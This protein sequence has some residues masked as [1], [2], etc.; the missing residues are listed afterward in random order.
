VASSRFVEHQAADEAPRSLRWAA[1]V[2]AVLAT[3][4]AAAYQL[5]AVA[6]GLHAVAVVAL[7]AGALL[8]SRRLVPERGIPWLVAGCAVMLIWTTQIEVYRDPSY[9]GMAYLLLLLTAF[10]PFVLSTA[11]FAVAVALVLPGQWVLAGMLEDGTQVGWFSISAAATLT[12][13]IV[14]RMRIDSVERLGAATL[15]VELL[16]SHDQLTGV[17]NRRGIDARVDAL[18]ASAARRS[19]PVMAVFVDVDGLKTA[20]DRGGHVYGDAVLSAVADALRSCTRGEDLVCRWGGDEFLVLGAG[21]A[22]HGPEL[23]Q[24]LMAHPAVR[25][26]VGPHWSGAV[27]VGA[28]TMPAAATTLDALVLA[29]DHAMYHR[30][31]TR[32][33]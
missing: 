25:S 16:A 33:S 17:L 9:L 5:T 22:P 15:D 26:V 21:D 27:T 19:E 3:F 11:A 8:A 24:R 23:E 10:G 13:W 14:L 32:S 20:N 4:N 7:L 29:A 30:R 2:V 6:N 1:V 31:T 18:I 12:G 28:V